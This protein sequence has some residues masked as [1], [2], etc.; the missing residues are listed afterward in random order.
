MSDVTSFSDAAGNAGVVPTITWG[1]V[2]GDR[3]GETKPKTW[4][5]CHATPAAVQRVEAEVARA[6]FERVSRLKTVLP[7][8][9]YAAAFDKTLAAVQSNQ[10]AFGQSLYVTAL[11]SSDGVLLSLFGCLGERHPDVTM[12]DVRGMFRDRRDEALFALGQVGAGFFACGAATT[13]GTLAEQAEM[14]AGLVKWQ[15]MRLG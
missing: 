3:P 12:A 6:A 7:A 8:D 15:V 2:P 9:Q 11:D 1:T 10:H 13:P 4:H 14:V 5:V